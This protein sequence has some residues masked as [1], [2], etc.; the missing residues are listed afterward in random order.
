MTVLV[1]VVNEAAALGC[2]MDFS[3]L[4]I[5]LHT[6]WYVGSNL[7]ILMIQQIFL[8]LQTIQESTAPSPHRPYNMKFW[9]E[10]L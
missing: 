1:S 7:T 5:A 3:S 6:R 10:Q 8:A 2:S 9:E 4:S